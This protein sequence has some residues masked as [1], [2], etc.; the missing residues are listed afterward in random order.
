M[1]NVTKNT[2]NKEKW[3]VLATLVEKCDQKHYDRESV[4][5]ISYAD[6]KICP[7][8]KLIKKMWHD[9]VTLIKKMIQKH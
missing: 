7:I 9:L 8:T 6:R 3:H 1:K 5:C 4:T 2:A